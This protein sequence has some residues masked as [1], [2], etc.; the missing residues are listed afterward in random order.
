MQSV[1][2]E[3]QPDAD[4]ASLFQAIAEPAQDQQGNSGKVIAT[5]GK[6]F[7]LSC[8]TNNGVTHSMDCTIRLSPSPYAQISMITQTADFKIGGEAAKLLHQK[9]AG[10]NPAQD[11]TWKSSLTGLR[12]HSTEAQFQLHYSAE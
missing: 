1:S 10:E 6:E 3:V 12:L 8:A 7:V 5:P 9:F 2:D 4:E 11:W